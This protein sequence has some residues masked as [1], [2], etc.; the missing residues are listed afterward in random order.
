ML[1]VGYDRGHLQN[2]TGG[3]A[4]NDVV[5]SGTTIPTTTHMVGKFTGAIGVRLYS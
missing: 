3:F 4:I 2:L 5:A 1:H